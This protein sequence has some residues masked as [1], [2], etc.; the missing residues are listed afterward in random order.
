MSNFNMWIIIIPLLLAANFMLGW[1]NIQRRG[2]LDPLRCD[3]GNRPEH[4]FSRTCMVAAG[5]ATAITLVLLIVESHRGIIQLVANWSNGDLEEAAFS[6]VIL[7]PF[8]A[9]IVFLFFVAAYHLG[10]WL[11]FRA[12]KSAQRH[13]RNWCY[14]HPHR[15]FKECPYSDRTCETKEA[16][17][18]AIAAEEKRQRDEKWQD[19]LRQIDLGLSSE[20]KLSVVPKEQPQTVVVVEPQPV[21]MRV[22]R[23]LVHTAEDP[24]GN[25]RLKRLFSASYTTKG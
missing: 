12:A 22:D 15:A 25:V 9:L 20:P 4:D 6:A 23:L 8:A 13:Q 14:D 3:D 10:D 17:A 18:D 24:E 21:G 16:V 11:A 7:S 1:H 2:C 5:F 19:M